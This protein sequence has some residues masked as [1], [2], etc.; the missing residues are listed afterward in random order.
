MI[1]LLGVG[2]CLSMAIAGKLVESFG[3]K[4]V[5]LLA[6]FIGMVSLAIVTMCPTIATTT[7]ALFFFGIG[8]GL[9]GASANLQ[10][11]LTEKVSKKHLM[12]A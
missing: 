7:V 3:C 9:S 5:V 12:G 10:A 8:V 4:R 11:I 1:L 2:S 6:S